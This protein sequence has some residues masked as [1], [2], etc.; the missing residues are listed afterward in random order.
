MATMIIIILTTTITRSLL[1]P[2]LTMIIHLPP[3]LITTI[4]DIN[5]RPTLHSSRPPPRFPHNC[6]YIQ[7]IICKASSCTFLQM[8]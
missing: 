3:T 5:I 8:H 7:T 2:T 6:T 1:H 4:L